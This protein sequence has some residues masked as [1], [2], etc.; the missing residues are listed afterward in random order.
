MKRKQAFWFLIQNSYIKGAS[1]E[2][3]KD[4]LTGR[5]GFIKFLAGLFSGLFLA[6]PKRGQARS[7][8]IKN[9]LRNLEIEAIKKSRPKRRPSITWNSEGEAITILHRKGEA[10]PICALNRVGKTILDECNG[11]NTP[12]KIARLL[13]ENYQVTAKDTY[14]DCLSFLVDLNKRGVVE[15]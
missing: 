3:N 8:E 11:R 13:Q 2:L 4:L 9:L 14:A 15:L 6:I 5:R 12:K 10:K 1:M 7:P